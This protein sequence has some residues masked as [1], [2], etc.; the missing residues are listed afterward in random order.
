MTEHKTNFKPMPF[1]IRDQ[2]D[3]LTQMHPASYGLRRF[4]QVP[5]KKFQYLRVKKGPGKGK[6]RKEFY[7]ITYR[8]QAYYLKNIKVD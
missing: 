4:L 2:V 6:I 5:V 3:E 8:Y 1:L 7:K